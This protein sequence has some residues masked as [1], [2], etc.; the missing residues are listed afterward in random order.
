MKENRTKISLLLLLVGVAILLNLCGNRNSSNKS[1][2]DEFH[3]SEEPIP[4][5]EIH[6][7]NENRISNMQDKPEDNL[8]SE[9]KKERKVEVQFKGYE[10]YPG[11]FAWLREEDWKRFQEE[12]KQYL[13]VK[14]FETVTT[15][16]LHPDTIQIINEYERNL[17]FDID[18]RTDTS[19]TLT[20]KTVCDTYQERGQMR[21]GF[22]IQYGTGRE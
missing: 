15:V 12:V 10:E 22:E 1:Q 16:N 2:E 18:Y 3:V 11:K 14:G 8:P 19:D 13:Y 21:F 9:E 20:I 4:E 5:A 6:E 17:Y 7:W